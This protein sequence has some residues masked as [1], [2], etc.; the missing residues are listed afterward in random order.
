MNEKKNPKGKL[1]HE[2]MHVNGTIHWR[3]MHK[4]ILKSYVATI[5]SAGR[6]M[7]CQPVQILRTSFKES[8]G[9]SIVHVG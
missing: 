1:K 7:D 9:A 5:R 4:K 3:C 6:A 8:E 2:G